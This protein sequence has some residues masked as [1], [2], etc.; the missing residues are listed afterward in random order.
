MSGGKN[1]GAVS[2]ADLLFYPEKANQKT[3]QEE[4]AERRQIK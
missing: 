1:S 4:V 3:F 2:Q